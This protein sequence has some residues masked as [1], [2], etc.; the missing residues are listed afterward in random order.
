MF[1]TI[2]PK[3][4]ISIMLMFVISLGITFCLYK[5]TKVD[6]VARFNYTIVVDAGHGGLDVK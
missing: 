6:A 4:F 5:V 2:K 3:V 1:F